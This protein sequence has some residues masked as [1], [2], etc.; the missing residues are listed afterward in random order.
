MKNLTIFI[1]C[2]IA[3]A[4]LHA[5]SASNPGTRYYYFFSKK[6]FIEKNFALYLEHEG[7]LIMFNE[8]GTTPELPSYFP[9]FVCLG[10]GD[11]GKLVSNMFHGA[12]FKLSTFQPYEE[13]NI[14]E[15]GTN[16]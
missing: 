3:A 1:A 16:F 11:E 7:K 2:L 10:S 8:V 14:R 13:E 5:Q 6:A 4:N 15:R 9:D 12:V